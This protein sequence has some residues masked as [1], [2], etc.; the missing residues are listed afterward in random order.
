MGGGGRL[1]VR[2]SLH[3]MEFYE[4]IPLLGTVLPPVGRHTKLRATPRSAGCVTGP[5]V[6]YREI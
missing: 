6:S 2:T 4:V 3:M 1:E 5:W